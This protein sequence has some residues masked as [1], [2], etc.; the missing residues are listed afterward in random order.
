MNVNNEP[1]TKTAPAFPPAAFEFFL[2]PGF[3][4]CEATAKVIALLET[5]GAWARKNLK[6]LF[7]S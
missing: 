2:E 1:P 6:R 5:P 4:G 3:D 7:K